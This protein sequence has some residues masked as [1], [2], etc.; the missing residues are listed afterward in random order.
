MIVDDPDEAYPDAASAWRRFRLLFLSADGLIYFA[1]VTRL[2][3]YEA[4]QEFYDDNVQYLEIRSL[5]TESYESNGTTHD[6]EWLLQTYREVSKQFVKDH[7]D[8]VGSKIIATSSRTSSNVSAILAAIKDVINLRRKFPD[9][10][11]G[12]DIV[13]F[14]DE[15]RSLFDYVDALLY[16]SQNSIDLK[17]FF[18][19]GETDWEGT[20]VDMNLFDA[21]LLNTS[22]IGHGY[23]A[24]KH[25]V[26]LQKI[27]ERNIGVEICPI[28]NQ[29]LRLVKDLRNHPGAALMS[30]NFPVVIS[31]DDPGL[32]GASGLSYDFY[33]ALMGLG[34]AWADLAT[35]K[36]LAMNSI[37]QSSLSAAEKKATFQLWSEKWDKFVRQSVE[38]LQL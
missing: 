33:E 32:W 10:L 6:K 26:V 20:S 21:I 5:L 2:Y 7:S 3:V 4:L 27:K 15:G 18:H 29:V 11:V 35:L 36:Q 34:G 31:S 37:M 19:A 9:T 16:P 14:E 24:L 38:E 22:R 30:D 17:Y 25:P 13:G 12:Y 1:P 23:A 28:S 8:F